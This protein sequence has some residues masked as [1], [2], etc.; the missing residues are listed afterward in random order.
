MTVVLWLLCAG[1]V[2]MFAAWLHE[3]RRNKAA[4]H[5][6]RETLAAAQ[7][8]HERELHDQ[9]A[10]TAALFDRMV[11]GVIVTDEDGRVLLANRAAHEFFNIV[12][13]AAGQTLLE[14]TR[15]HE[16]AAVAAR[17]A[18]ETEVLGYEARLE[19]AVAR[20]HLQ[21][22]AVGLRGAAGE[23]NGAL[24]VFHDLTR[25]RTLEATRQDFVANVSHELRTPLSL[26]KSAAETLLDGAKDDPDALNRFLQIIDKHANRLTSLIEDLLLLGTLDSGQLRLDLEPVQLRE[27]VREVI[28]DLA[29]RARARACTLETSVP[30]NLVAYA[31]RGR[32]RQ[33]F[34]NL[35]DNAIKYGSAGG[36][37]IVSAAPTAGDRIE[38]AVRDDGPGL[39]PEA[40]S[41][42]FERFYRVDKA[43][44]REQGGTGLG[45]AIVKHV[46]QAHG[47]EVRVESTLGLGAAFFFTLPMPPA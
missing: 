41:R 26:I 32:L 23:R 14:A 20:R 19:G 42:V 22:N 46:V 17:L 30:A 36:H 28:D 44:S 29:V 39:P 38:V 8:R 40:L 4:A 45:L 10:R 16:I 7:E 31:D 35:I 5:N 33:V 2:G 12:P 34:S 6:H 47:G 9:A 18:R 43:R 1:L 24:L 15:Q 3:R 27:I 13:P 11:E 37:V 25:L 21:I